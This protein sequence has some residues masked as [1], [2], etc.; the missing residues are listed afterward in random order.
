MALDQ[1]IGMVTAYAYAV[2]KGYTG[3][4]EQFAQE[5]ASA[6]A[7]LS[8]IQT[9][10]DNF[11]NT[12]VPAKT[13]EVTAE[14][15]RQIGLVAAEGT[16]QKN[17]VTA[18]GTTQKNAVISE[19]TTQKNA[20]NSAG[21]TQV[22]AVNSAGSTQVGNVNTAGS[23]Q[24][25]AVQAKGQEVLNSIPSD[26]SELSDDVDDL[27]SALGRN[28]IIKASPNNRMSL[29]ADGSS[30]EVEGYVLELNSTDGTGYNATDI[31]VSSKNL[32]PVATETQTVNGCVITY[33]NGIL[34]I[35]GT[36]S[37]A[38]WVNFN[39][40]TTF[41]LPK[42]NYRMTLNA[43]KTAGF[44]VTDGDLSIGTTIGYA[45]YRGGKSTITN[46]IPYLRNLYVSLYIRVGK[47]YDEVIQMLLEYDDV[48]TMEWDAPSGINK[49]TLSL[50]SAAGSVQKG[51][52]TVESDGSAT[53]VS[54]LGGNTGTYTFTAPTF[55]T[56]KGSNV[57]RAEVEPS[58][59][60]VRYIADPALAISTNADALKNTYVPI[61]PI[62]NTNV[63]GIAHRGYT[64]TAPEDTLPAYI[65]AKK[66]GF[67]YV[68]TDMR[69]TSDGV[70]VLL[71]D[72]TINRTGRNA[73]G[74]VISSTIY[75]ANI[76]YAEALTYD[77]G[78][79]TGASYAGTKIP[80]VDQ[81][82]ALCKKIGLHPYCEFCVGDTTEAQVQNIIDIA[83]KYGM[84]NHVTWISFNA[85]ILGYVKTYDPTARIGLVADS[86]DATIV[87]NAQALKT[88]TNEVFI[89]SG[90]T[91]TAEVN[92]C[93]AARIPLEAWTINDKESML[94]LDPYISGVTSNNHDY[95]AVLYE[96]VMG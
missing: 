84:R 35:R 20:V 14:G 12:I 1:N 3:T 65:E 29:I 58:T 78:I 43:L 4:E 48:S 87:S 31:R 38:S 57:I 28:L 22:N 9:Q 52:V 21:F 19:G 66:H 68:E 26:Y 39:T 10:I 54:T 40:N 79:L 62:F 53:L 94:A 25:G 64:P 51:T 17:A 11:I 46:S 77:F 69:F 81:L 71:H 24:V 93:K 91:T 56:T 45:S 61:Q 13:A 80:T 6:G 44:S 59:I 96:S 34:T 82:M 36:A 15:T 47:A 74:T 41:Q 7:D 42:G 67:M 86:V 70:P 90:T 63:K 50:P 32:L 88:D 37:A 49:Y 27:K 72:Q 92:L 55:S 2:S 75:I 60:S 30:N 83:D 76:T 95:S 5:L 89:S 33:D 8:Q 18:E 85:T 73:D 16:A 23:T